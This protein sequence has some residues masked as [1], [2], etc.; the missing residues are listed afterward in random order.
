MSS[1]SIKAVF[2]DIGG[3]VVKS[4]LLGIYKFEEDH[5]LPPNY[6]NV[7]MSVFLDCLS[8]CFSFEALV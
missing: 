4:P 5:G 2:F 1:E 8:F 6:M 7:Q 3:V